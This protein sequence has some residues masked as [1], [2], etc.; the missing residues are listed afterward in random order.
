MPKTMQ[1][2]LVWTGF[3]QGNIF[4]VIPLKKLA[5]SAKKNILFY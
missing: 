1:A 3:R 2:G 4:M 5:V